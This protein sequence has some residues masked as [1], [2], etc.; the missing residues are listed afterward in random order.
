MKKKML[1]FMKLSVVMA[2]VTLVVTFAA[3]M[4]NADMKLI[5]KIYD[6]LMKHHD[7]REITDRI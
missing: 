1:R 2:L 3:F 6:L 4:T 7:S 5:E